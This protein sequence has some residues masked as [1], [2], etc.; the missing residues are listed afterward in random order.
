MEN[1]KIWMV[2]H[3]A[4]NAVLGIF[5][6]KLEAIKGFKLF[7]DRDEMELITDIDKINRVDFKTET[8][9]VRVKGQR[10]ELLHLHYTYLNN[11]AGFIALKIKDY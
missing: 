5:S 4:T 11:S 2:T 9:R 8:I 10:L 6:S 3:I 1:D 7:F